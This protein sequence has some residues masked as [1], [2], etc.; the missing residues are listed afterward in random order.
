MDEARAYPPEVARAYDLLVEGR[1]DAE[2]EG[3]EVQFVLRSLRQEA[4]REVRDVLDVGCGTGRHLIPLLREGFSVRGMDGSAAMVA[5]CRRKLVRR[6]LE[7]PIEVGDLG[8]LD[9][10][11][12]FDAVLCMNSVICYLLETERIAGALR[13]MRRALRP[14]GLLILDNAN[15]LAQWMSFGQTYRQKRTGPTMTIEF[16]ERRLFEDFNSILHIEVEAT[17]REGEESYRF[18]NEDLLRVVTVGEMSAYLGEAGFEA[19]S[20]YPSFDR[21]LWEEGCGDR[22]IHLALRPVAASRVG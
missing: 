16:T 9:C 15:L 22:V 3:A 1:E 10:G 5:E 19:L 4:R 12:S 18:R 11:A 17:V 2:A 20:A 14:G 21:S 7:A 13:V 8:G 6:G